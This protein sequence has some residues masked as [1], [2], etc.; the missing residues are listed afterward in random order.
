MLD[1]FHASSRQQLLDRLDRLA[2]DSPRQW[3]KMSPAQMLAHCANA[4]EVAAGEQP[5]KQALIG[6][7]L[8]PFVRK[9]F[10]GEAPF[11]R[12]SPTDPGFVIADSRE[13]A[14]EKQRLRSVVDR[15]V[16]LGPEHAA[17]CTHSFFGRLSGEEWGLLM[18]KHLDHH[19]RQFG[20]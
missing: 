3:G 19:L 10:L 14:A 5:R 17:A 1:L 12:S 9:K 7:L 6:R 15:F 13:F 8:S 20:V 4:L 18:G 16:I 11:P 2:P